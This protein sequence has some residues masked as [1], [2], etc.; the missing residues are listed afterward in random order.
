MIV[1]AIGQSL[2]P[3]NEQKNHWSSISANIKGSFNWIGI[4]NIVIDDLIEMVIQA[5]DR[6][7]LIASTKAL[8]RVL[9]SNHYL[10]PHWHI[11][12]WRLAYWNKIKRPQYLPKYGLGFPQI[13][14]HN[15]KN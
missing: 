6:Q 14:W 13:W 1:V 9:L 15:E 7:E 11:K 8:D 2:S 5:P 4:K 10:I 3:G 12:K